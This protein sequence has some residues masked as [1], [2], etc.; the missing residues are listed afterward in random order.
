MRSFQTLIQNPFQFKVLGLMTC[1][2][3]SV[4]SYLTYMRSASLLWLHPIHLMH[5]CIV[6]LSHNPMKGLLGLI[7]FHYSCFPYGKIL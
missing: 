3:T 6:S 4:S 7:L 1:G 5:T 2:R